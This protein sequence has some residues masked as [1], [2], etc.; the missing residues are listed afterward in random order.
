MSPSLDNWTSLF[1]MAA[2]F[3]VF[4]F[5][6][7]IINNRKGSNYSIAL[8]VLAF[9]LI[10]VQYVLY[11]SGYQR[12]F[13]YLIQL[14]AMCYY[15]SGPLLYIYFYKIYFGGFKKI[16]LLNFLP[17]LLI[18]ISA[19]IFILKGGFKTGRHAIQHDCPG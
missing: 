18:L 6:L 7:L 15:A 9:S 5:I 17:S 4:M 11:W 8:L 13:P 1:L 3:G 10:L 16:F 19:I 2:G 12:Q 14:P